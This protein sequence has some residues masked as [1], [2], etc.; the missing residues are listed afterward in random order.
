[1]KQAEQIRKEQEKRE[2]KRKKEEEE[3]QFLANNLTFF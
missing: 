2:A 3:V 1:M